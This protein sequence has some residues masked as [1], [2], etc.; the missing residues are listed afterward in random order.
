MNYGAWKQFCVEEEKR[1]EQMR[2]SIL[3][4]CTKENNLPVSCSHRAI[5]FFVTPL[6]EV[7]G[8]DDYIEV[9]YM[10]VK[11]LIDEGKL[12]SDGYRD[13]NE[14]FFSKGK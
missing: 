11:A 6:D 2:E 13:G 3:K 12:I 14:V 9:D 1:K 10:V 4:H 8:E 7:Y 5:T